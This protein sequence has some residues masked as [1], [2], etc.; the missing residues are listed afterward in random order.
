M[1][2]YCIYCGQDKEAGH[3]PEC[4]III[5][6]PKC[7]WGMYS[8]GGYD[9]EYDLH[10]GRVGILMVIRD[11]KF[12][13]FVRDKKVAY[14]LDYEEEAFIIRRNKSA[15]KTCEQE[16]RKLSNSWWGKRKMKKLDKEI[17][18]IQNA[19]SATKIRE[20]A[21]ATATLLKLEAGGVIK[22]YN[23]LLETEKQPPYI[24]LFRDEVTGAFTHFLYNLQNQ[25]IVIEGV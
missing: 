10:L 19:L 2:I 12:D 11:G 16:R 8:T 23:S 22:A 14:R 5:G 24:P 20:R 4:P 7:I 6:A 15:L 13:L 18:K 1:S 3:S 9:L 25:Y 17:G 21:E